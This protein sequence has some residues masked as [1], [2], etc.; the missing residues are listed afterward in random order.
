MNK[1]IWLD[2][3][4]KLRDMLTRL[5]DDFGCDSLKVATEDA[6]MSFEEIS[7]VYRLFNDILPIAMKIGGPEARNDIH[8]AVQIGVACIIAP[9]IESVYALE[10]FIQTVEEV[11][12]KIKYEKLSK[13]IN[14]ETITACDNIENIINSKCI[15]AIHQVT[16]GR[17]DLSRSIRENVDSQRMLELT[18]KIVDISRAKN[19]E[20]SVG[21]NITPENAVKI[22]EMATPDKINTREI[23]FTVI[24]SSNIYS[25]VT[26]MLKFERELIVHKINIFNY[27]IDSLADRKIKIEKR[28]GI[29]SF[30]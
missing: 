26:E 16:I 25:T 24:K 2:S 14:I 8:N 12:G 27:Q 21:G 30:V 6:G 23:G 20:V 9:M 3:E 13:Q 29:G 7:E 19:I 4:K 22:A 15:E 1:I 17:T 5:R 28:V 10:K 11:A 18:K